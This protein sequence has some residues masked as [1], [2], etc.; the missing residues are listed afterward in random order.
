[1][2]GGGL[3]VFHQLQRVRSPKVSLCPLDRKSKA[4]IEV[5]SHFCGIKLWTSATDK[6]HSLEQALLEHIICKHPA[7]S[8]ALSRSASSCSSF[9]TLENHTCVPEVWSAPWMKPSQRTGGSA[10]PFKPVAWSK[11]QR[12]DST[13]LM[14]RGMNVCF[15]HENR[16]LTWDIHRCWFQFNRVKDS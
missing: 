15:L 1:M 4:A 14:N 13:E 12:K 6:Q 9:G 2:Q 10:Q 5:W 7:L 11:A 8:L 3:Q 16:G